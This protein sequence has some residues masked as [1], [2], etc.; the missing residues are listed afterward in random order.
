MYQGDRCDE[1]G[2]KPDRGHGLSLLRTNE[3]LFL[4]TIMQPD[5]ERLSQIGEAARQ[6]VSVDCPDMGEGDDVAVMKMT[7]EA[8]FH[9]PGG[10][11]LERWLQTG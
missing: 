8:D 7:V 2:G 3:S 4:P 11:F 6:S 1:D 9:G 10:L 5:L